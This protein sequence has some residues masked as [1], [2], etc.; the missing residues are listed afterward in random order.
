MDYKLFTI[1]IIVTIVALSSISIN[2]A[3][4]DI[5][6]PKLQSKL[7]VPNES[8]LCETGMFK[9]IRERTNSAACINAQNV[10]KLV[11]KGWAQPVDEEKLSK[12]I[13]ELTPTS[14]KITE[15]L[16]T[17]IKSDFK[18]PIGKTSIAEYGYV[19]EV[20]ASSHDLVSPEVIINSDSETINYE[21]AET[22]SANSCITSATSI[23]ASNPDTIKANLVSKGDIS[24]MIISIQ[25][26]VN[27]IKADLLEAK[28][29]LGKDKPEENQKQGNKIVDLRKQLNDA[30][31]ELQR[32]YF[33]L[34]SSSKTVSPIEKM[35]FSGTQIQDYTAT[36][37]SI[38][39]SVAAKDTFDVVFE[40][41]AGEKQVRIPII[42]ISSD[43]EN[44]N[45]KLGDKI[46]PNTCQLTSAKVIAN[47]PQSVTIKVAGN[48]E[49]STKVLDLEAKIADLQIQLSITKEKLRDLV[50]NSD[51]P[52]NFNEQATSLV[53]KT[54]KLRADIISSK[55]ELS[56]ILYQTYR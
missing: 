41:C 4:A 29:S 1:F 54:S 38:R 33:F 16:V 15:I 44:K 40:A 52:E 45:V 39:E 7:G 8:I 43:S 50:H 34:Y 22:I 6:P 46:A 32:Y 49:S 37:I 42:M 2:F 12:F 55:A 23:K 28:Q 19:F 35:S 3:H 27:T 9:V 17:P 53:E 36:I 13:E 51:R 48:S 5:I 11:T 30:R 10:S 31:A 25:N 21:L 20:C 47:D 56:K 24:R 26:K 14:G 18:K